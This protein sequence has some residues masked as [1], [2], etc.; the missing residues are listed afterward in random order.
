MRYLFLFLLVFCSAIGLN[1]NQNQGDTFYIKIHF[2]Y[3][4]KPAREFRHE[5]SRWF[6]G[7]LGGH[8]GIETDSGV[9]LNFIPS[10]SFHWFAQ[11]KNRHSRF[12]THGFHHFMECMGGDTDSN[13]YLSVTIQITSEQKKLLDSVGRA[14]LSETPFDYAFFGMRCAAAA[15]DVLAAIGVMPDYSYRRTWRKMFYPKLLRRKILKQ[16]EANRWRAVHH[17]GTNRRNWEKD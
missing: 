8:V 4:S 6:G 17:A 9:I 5:E 14:Y 11:Q 3:G 7:K 1:A 16:A 15:Y 2:L 12:T 10:G 13:K